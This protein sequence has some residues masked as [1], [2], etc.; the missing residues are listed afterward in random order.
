RRKRK[1]R[2]AHNVCRNATS[3]WRAR[4]RRLSAR[5]RSS[6]AAYSD[7]Y[8]RRI[9]LEEGRLVVKQLRALDWMAIDGASCKQ[10]SSDPSIFTGG[11]APIFWL[12]DPW[13]S[14]TGRRIPECSGGTFVLSPQGRLNSL[15]LRE[16]VIEPPD[17]RPLTFSRSHR[18]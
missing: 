15:A 1:L 14:P 5:Q 17:G 2:G 16:E 10:N 12:I 3:S 6:A 4:R 18:E 7:Y 9:D 8:Y 13:P 11:D